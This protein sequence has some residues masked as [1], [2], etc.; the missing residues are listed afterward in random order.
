MATAAAAAAVGAC[1]GRAH[2]ALAPAKGKTRAGAGTLFRAADVR[3]TAQLDRAAFDPHVG[4]TFAVQ[5]SPRDTVALSLA[6]VAPLTAPARSRP[7]VKGGEAFSLAF[8]G[9][10][11]A[12]PQGSY[13]VQ[14]AE[15]GHFELFLAPVGRGGGDYEA[16]FN[17]LWR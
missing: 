6:T 9:P 16:V 2:K 1:T 10:V 13:P 14:H 17:R 15:L 8:T 4:S 5:V 12:V 7:P 11:K 3:R